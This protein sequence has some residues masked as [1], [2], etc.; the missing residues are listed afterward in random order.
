MRTLYKSALLALLAIGILMIGCAPPPPYPLSATDGDFT[1]KVV[2]DWTAW[3]QAGNPVTVLRSTDPAGYPPA[4]YVELATG[5]MGSYDDTNATPGI[6]YFY[7]VKTDSG[8]A[9]GGFDGG[10]AGATPNNF[11]G[12]VG[13][14]SCASKGIADLWLATYDIGAGDFPLTGDTPNG[15]SENSANVNIASVGGGIFQIAFS[16]TFFL[17]TYTLPY[18]VTGESVLLQDPKKNG[19]ARGVAVYIETTNP[20]TGNHGISASAYDIIEGVPDASRYV[21]ATACVPGATPCWTP[22]TT[23]YVAVGNPTCP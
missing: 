3:S 13:A 5:Q 6:A 20:A 8:T 4:P 12:D 15:Q 19:W 7:M 22:A 23:G 11:P 21:Y 1:D 9:L 16:S 2:V 14:W 10:F 17:D 18:M